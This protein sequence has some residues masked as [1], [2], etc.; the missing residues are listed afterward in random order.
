MGRAV[1]PRT[2]FFIAVG[3]FFLMVPALLN[4]FPFIFPD[5]GDYLTL[6][7]HIHRPPFYGLFITFAH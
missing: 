7:P 4:G 1:E 5:S 3:A 2:A 6:T